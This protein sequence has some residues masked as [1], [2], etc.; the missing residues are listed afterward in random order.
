VCA[1]FVLLTAYAILDKLANLVLY[2]WE[3]VVSLN[4]FYCSYNTRVSM[5]Q[6]VVI[7]AN[8]FFF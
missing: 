5:Q 6:V 4:K 3:L 2:V 8:N 1:V 7:T